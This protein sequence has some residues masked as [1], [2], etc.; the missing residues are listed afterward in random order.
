MTPLLIHH[1]TRYRYSSPVTLGEHR[2]LLRPRAGHDI[3]FVSSDL[4]IMP[5]PEKL[6]WARDVYGNS[7]A[8]A[9]FSPVSTT[10]LF[11]RSD[12]RIEHYDEEPLK[13]LV[14]SR[15][16]KFPYLLL[17][18]ERI[19]LWPYLIPCYLDDQNRVAEWADKFWKAERRVETFAL[20]TEMNRTIANTFTYRPREEAGVQRPKETLATRSGSCRDFATLLIESCRYLGLPARFVSGYAHTGEVPAALG[21]THAWTEVFIPGAGWK[22]FD[23]TG[24]IVTG[25]AHIAVAVGRDPES[26]PP[27][28]GSFHSADRTVKSELE[29][30]VSVTS[31]PQTVGQ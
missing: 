25:P 3:R 26:L 19:E 9:N 24:G 31:S 5:P 28:A 8:H 16:A 27:I 11:I 1:A 12:I 2:L 30:S 4:V 13:F 10:E 20:L 14:D 21:A 17:P 29:V 6:S 7:V 23:S 18:S 22:G 15:A